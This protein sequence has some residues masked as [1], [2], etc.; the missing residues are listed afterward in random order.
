MHSQRLYLLQRPALVRS[1]NQD[2]CILRDLCLVLASQATSI[3][4]ESQQIYGP[5]LGY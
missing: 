3:L 2:L 1:E 5:S 4:Q